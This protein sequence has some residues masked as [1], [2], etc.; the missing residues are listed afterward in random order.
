MGFHSPSNRSRTIS[1]D[2]QISL[3]NTTMPWRVMN[4]YAIERKGN[5]QTHRSTNIEVLRIVSIV[6]IV[7]SHC[8]VHTN[9]EGGMA[10]LHRAILGS[11]SL[12]EVGV[13]SFVL[14]TGYFLWN[15]PFCVSRLVRVLISTTTYSLLCLCIAALTEGTD[16]IDCRKYF[17]PT[18]YGTY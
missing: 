5:A 11:L 6:L 17:F 1:L 2:P 13:T 14:T 7:L 3:N 12:G 8:C 16:G 15:K 9:W 18:I 10:P 4:R